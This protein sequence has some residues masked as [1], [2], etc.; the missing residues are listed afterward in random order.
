M[1][2]FIEM[3]AAVLNYWEHNISKG[4]ISG[5]TDQILRVNELDWDYCH[6]NL[7]WKFQVS[8]SKDHKHGR[9]NTIE[10]EYEFVIRKN[11]IVRSL[12]K[13]FGRRIILK[14]QTSIRNDRAIIRRNN[15]SKLII[16]G[17]T[18]SELMTLA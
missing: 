11:W 14:I 10:F 4:N 16:S 9:R 3:K 17:K 8:G 6:L 5:T 18:L 1:Q 13:K 2:N 15:H 12:L 7:P